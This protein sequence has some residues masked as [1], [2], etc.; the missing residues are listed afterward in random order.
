MYL[1]YMSLP[2]HHTAPLPL[3]QGRLLHDAKELLLRDLS[4]SVSVGLVDHLLQLL[5]TPNIW[6]GQ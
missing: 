4:V 1:P 3:V 2:V 5:E 6:G